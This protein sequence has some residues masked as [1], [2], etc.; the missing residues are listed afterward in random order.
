[1]IGLRTFRAGLF[2][3]TFSFAVDDD[4]DYMC[5]GSQWQTNEGYQDEDREINILLLDDYLMECW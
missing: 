3:M 1:M 4:D 2:D 5:S